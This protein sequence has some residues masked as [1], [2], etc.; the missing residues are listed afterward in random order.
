MQGSAD[1]LNSAFAVLD[2]ES[3]GQVSLAELRQQMKN[4]GEPV[5]TFHTA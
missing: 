2:H 3:N 5:S 1:E 4:M